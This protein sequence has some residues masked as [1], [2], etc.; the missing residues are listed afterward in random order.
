MNKIIFTLVIL[1]SVLSI[2]SCAKVCVTSKSY[3]S[4]EGYEKLDETNYRS[5]KEFVTSIPSKNT[6]TY[7]TDKVKV[8]LNHCDIT[9]T[10]CY[11]LESQHNYHTIDASCIHFGDC[12][13]DDTLREFV[14]D[15]FALNV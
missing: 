10:N 2:S 15:S 7:K 14:P 11:K 13:R 5:Y 6:W 9:C 12:R 8:C 3:C 4:N 1:L